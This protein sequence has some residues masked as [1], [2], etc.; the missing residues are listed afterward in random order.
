MFVC[1]CRV[2]DRYV[3][4]VGH[5]VLGL[6][7][8]R[9]FFGAILLLPCP[10]IKVRVTVPGTG[11]CRGPDRTLHRGAVESA[12]RLRVSGC[13]RRE[14]GSG[15]RGTGLHGVQGDSVQLVPCRAVQIGREERSAASA[16]GILRAAFS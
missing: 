2:F 9:R 15:C 4:G 11:S 6:T 14:P 8:A 7:V 12:A 13:R 16:A 1:L 5:C 3:V 10:C